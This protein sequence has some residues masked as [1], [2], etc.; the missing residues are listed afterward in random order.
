MARARFDEGEFLEIFV[1]VP[2]ALAEA[3]DVK[4]LYR[5][6][7]AGQIPNFT[8]IDSPYEAPENAEIHLD[9]GSH[10]PEKLAALVLEKLGLA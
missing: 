5:K 3:R 1:D 7:R 8:G 10:S 2:L 9:A 6:A 4:G